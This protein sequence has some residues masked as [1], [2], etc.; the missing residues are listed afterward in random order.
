MLEYTSTVTIFHKHG[1]PLKEWLETLSR[2]NSE[3]CMRGSALVAQ[4]TFQPS[5]TYAQYVL[6]A[7]FSVPDID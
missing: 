3:R 1:H 2:L 5:K 4:F 7:L 6:A